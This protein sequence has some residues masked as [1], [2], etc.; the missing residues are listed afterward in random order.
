MTRRRACLVPAGLGAGLILL[1]VAD[2]LAQGAE[3]APLPLFLSDQAGAGAVTPPAS[4]RPDR[5]P[6]PPAAVEPAAGEP[7]E[8]APQEMPAARPE[9]VDTPPQAIAPLLDQVAFWRQ[10]GRGDMAQQAADRALSIAPD[11][12]DVLFQ[13]GLIA[14]ESGQVDQANR[15]LARLRALAPT[16]P[17][18][19]RLG[20]AI[21][22]GVIPKTLIAQARALSAKGR[23]EEAAAAYRQAFSNLPPPIEYAREY[24]MTLGGTERGWS[25]ARD[26]LA[27]LA[28]RAPD[29]IG[30]QIAYGQVL[31]YRESG[32]RD[33]IALLSHYAGDHE[34]ALNFWRAGLLWLDAGAPDNALFEAYLARYP[35]DEEVAA[36]Y[37]ALT[38]PLTADTPERAISLGLAA[39]AAKRPTAAAGYFETA[40]R[41]DPGNVNAMANL[42]SVRLGQG[43]PSDALT[44][45]ERAMAAAP[46]RRAEFAEAYRTARFLAAYQ[47]AVAALKARRYARA[48][49]LARPLA[50][51]G[52]KDQRLAQGLLADALA[53]QRK[54]VEAERIYRQVL[55]ARPDD[56]QA[57]RGL[58]GVLIRRNKL[59][60][61]RALAG[62]LPGV[63]RAQLA[64]GLN[65][66]AATRQRAAAEDLARAGQVDAASRSYQGALAAAPGD[67]WIRL[68]YARFLLHQGDETAAAGVMAPVS[69]APGADALYAAALFA[70][71][72]R[73]FDQ[74]AALM[75]RV[76]AA[77]RSPAMTAF[78][79]DIALR[80]TIARARSLDEAGN[81]GQAI[82][83]LRGLSTRTDLL[84]ATR[85][86]LASALYDMGDSEGALWLVRSE[87]GRGIAQSGQVTDYAALAGVLARDGRDGE[88][89]ALLQRLQPLARSATDR[90]VLQDLRNSLAAQRADQLR[91]QGR[92][93]DAYDE[94][95]PALQAEPD[96]PVLLAALARLYATG[97]RYPEA[98]TLYER[99]LAHQPNN[100]D[101]ALQAANVA[102]DGGAFE[103]AHAL[104]DPLLQ[105]PQPSARAYFLAGRL[106]RAEGD[107]AGAIEALERARDLRAAEL[108]VTRPTATPV[109]AG[110]VTPGGNPFRS[111][112]GPA[113]AAVPVAA[114]PPPPPAATVY[115]PGSFADHLS[116][117]GATSGQTV[118]NDFG[119]GEAA[120]GARGAAPQPA[121]PVLYRPSTLAMADA[122]DPLARDIDGALGELRR[123]VAP[124]AYGD[125]AFRYRTGES[126]LSRLTELGNTTSFT[127][128][129]GNTGRLTVAARPVFVDAGKANLASR[130]RFGS[131]PLLA[132][133]KPLDP[134]NQDDFGLALSASY[135]LSDFTVDVGTTPLGF[136][137]TRPQGG[138]T[139]APALTDALR[140]KVTVDRRSVTDSVLAYAG[141]KDPLSGRKWGGVMRTGGEA[142][143][144]YDQ[145]DGGAYG[146]VGYHRYDG[147]RVAGNAAWNGTFGAYLRPYRTPTAQLQVGAAFTYMNFNKNL[148]QFTLGHG[149]YFSPQ[150]YFSL[151]LPVSY[152]TTVRDWRFEVGGALGYQRF[153][154]EKAPYF[155][156]NGALQGALEARAA[157]N[158]AAKLP[159]AYGA[160][161]TSG[162]GASAKGRFEYDL[163]PGTTLGGAVGFDNS[164]D[165]HETTGQVFLRYNFGNWE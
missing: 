19:V 13:A 81:R 113:P 120:P 163:G 31:T 20:L 23:S 74:A 98:A 147:T 79:R 157:A 139:W 145:P 136:R 146:A 85:G 94:L 36:R 108:G 32:R 140:L 112:G 65:A 132:P 86:E 38:A 54:D 58:Y 70:V 144:Y 21:T 165:W 72:R 76:P 33:G 78:A 67:P 5:S 160:T 118:L 96:D 2:G 92:L 29:D 124:E 56:K 119:R 77:Q 116:L 49:Q 143:L 125:L 60:E 89:R 44:L 100:P 153:R 46:G 83:L 37:R 162:I 47:E 117:A 135:A 159:T 68:S 142:G 127:F 115:L 11:N 43:R 84:P 22:R 10:R 4:L 8:V 114:A 30:L 24:Y 1:S 66:A 69:A 62:R 15:H 41:L 40:L 52:N 9:A 55:K 137:F 148:S 149:G 7:A 138:V 91:L 18:T 129:P 150:N 75:A 3:N 95:A 87:L 16:D 105:R 17:R 110:A 57:L 156:G 134:G 123:V 63:D 126:G 34:D 59:A 50:T 111:G 73:R 106:A 99:L 35:G 71:D 26:G 88:A 42:A 141:A 28:R 80:D 121:V 82:A 154:Q 61:A 103:R 104:I 101:L 128:S 51:G 158:P 133:A 151:G 45:L 64:G 130:R 102:I 53:A 27:G 122:G 25:V 12:L 107:V 161:T 14:A 155:P 48:E 6:A 93:A 109:P 39:A 97:Q 131:N 164:G 152:Q 90:R